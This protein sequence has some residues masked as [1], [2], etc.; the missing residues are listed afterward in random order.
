M[1]AAAP[2]PPE[3]TPP[4]GRNGPANGLALKVE[5]LEARSR[6]LGDGVDALGSGQRSMAVAAEEA[7][8]EAGRF[9]DEL[10][11][12][13]RDLAALVKSAVASTV[14]PAAPAPSAVAPSAVVPIAGASGAVAPTAAV[15][16]TVAPSA[17]APSAV[18]PRSATVPAAAQPPDD[19]IRIIAENSVAERERSRVEAEERDWPW[20]KSMRLALA[21]QQDRLRDGRWERTMRFCTALRAGTLSPEAALL[22]VHGLRL[23]PVPA[24]EREGSFLE[25]LVCQSAADGRIEGM[26]H[27]HNVRVFPLLSPSLQLRV[28]P[29][30]HDLPVIL[31][32]PSPSHDWCTTHS[33]SAPAALALA[34][35]DWANEAIA[36]D[37]A[38]VRGGAPPPSAAKAFVSSSVFPRAP[39]RSILTRPPTVEG[40]APMLFPTM[41]DEG[42]NMWTDMTTVHEAFQQ[43]ATQ[44]GV[45]QARIVAGDER[46]AALEREV[47]ALRSGQAPATV[48]KTYAPA[49]AAQPTPR[50]PAP[51]PRRRGQGRGTVRPGA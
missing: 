48:P 4:R 6:A 32:P 36:D 33:V 30:V 41:R 10:R 7:A 49:R 9:R 44:V 8:K 22:M 1:S 35:F 3:G 2:P 31:F 18:A 17:I 51:Q 50:T 27:A 38:S 47:A 11:T 23:V 16:S 21:A 26:I 19:H 12:E 20:K 45:M 28:G 46:M 24:G 25:A 34:N 40:G 43:Q 5:A 29:W 14:T 42:G 15:P 39:R 13:L 37:L